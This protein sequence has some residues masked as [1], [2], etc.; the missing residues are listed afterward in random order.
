MTHAFGHAEHPQRLQSEVCVGV[1]N[2]FGCHG[3]TANRHCSERQT[4]APLAQLSRLNHREQMR[5]DR[6]GPAAPVFLGSAKR[7]GGH[8]R[9][10]EDEW[11]PTFLPDSEI[12]FNCCRGGEHA[13]PVQRAPIAEL[14]D[15]STFQHRLTATVGDVGA[16]RLAAAA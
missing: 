2:E 15:V 8:P 7:I 5:R 16:P 9:I 10:D 3:A 4:A 13:G 12:T 14:L 6:D 1:G 11:M